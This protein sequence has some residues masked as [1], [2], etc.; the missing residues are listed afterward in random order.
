MYLCLLHCFQNEVLQL[1]LLCTQASDRP[2]QLALQWTV[3]KS[4][5]NHN[6]KKNPSEFMLSKVMEEICLA[7]RNCCPVVVSHLT[8]MIIEGVNA[9]YRNLHVTF[10]VVSNSS[11][12]NTR[13]R[14]LF[15]Y[16]KI[17]GLSRTHFPFFKHS[18][19]C[20]KCLELSSTTT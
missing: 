5:L 13:V 6:L 9:Y 16:K 1:L 8:K 17:Q 18:I 7:I 10:D 12:V 2:K 20:K 15:L 4:L 19:Q 11:K 3:S 14:T